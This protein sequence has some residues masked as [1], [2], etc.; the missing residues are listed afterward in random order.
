MLEAAHL[1][2]HAS[3]GTNDPRNGL[4]MNVALHRAFDA[5]LF[6]IHPDTRKVVTR[7]GGPDLQALGITSPSLDSL[8]KLPHADALKHRFEAWLS[9]QPQP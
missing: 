3:D 4:V 6:A 1:V 9:L 2:P 8:A 7:P 5:H